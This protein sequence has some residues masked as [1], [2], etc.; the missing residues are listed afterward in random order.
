MLC[1]LSFF[2]SVLDTNLGSFPACT[3][4]KL[5]LMHYVLYPLGFFSLLASCHLK[6]VPLANSG[7]AFVLSLFCFLFGAIS[8]VLEKDGEDRI[9][10]LKRR[11]WDETREYESRLSESNKGDNPT[12]KEKRV[13]TPPE[14]T[15]LESNFYKDRPKLFVLTKKGLHYKEITIPLHKLKIEWRDGIEGIHIDTHYAL[16]KGRYW[17][18]R[19]DIDGDFQHLF[20]PYATDPLKK[21]KS[22]MSSMQRDIVCVK[23]KFS[24]QRNIYLKSYAGEECVKCPRCG[25]NFEPSRDN[26]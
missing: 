11:L 2:K 17:I 10:K 6:D 4:I 21:Q 22:S 20:R 3:V 18:A 14:K 23:C 12:P 26:F 16:P 13:V 15:K 25:M 9:S 19:A 24:A 8:Q 1:T 7:A 5:D